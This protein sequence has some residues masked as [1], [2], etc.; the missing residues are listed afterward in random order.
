MILPTVDQARRMPLKDLERALTRILD[1][2]TGA[3]VGERERLREDW[4]RLHPILKQ[5]SRSSRTSKRSKR[6]AG[7]TSPRTSRNRTRP[8]SGIAGA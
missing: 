3:G 2:S 5:R 7:S 8:W 1:A 4:R 6:P